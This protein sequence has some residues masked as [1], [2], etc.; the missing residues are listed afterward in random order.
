MKGVRKSAFKMPSFLT[1]LII[2]LVVC[3]LIYLAFCNVKN[4]DGF[5]YGG[6]NANKYTASSKQVDVNFNTNS[7]GDVMYINANYK[8][9]DGVGAVHIHTNDNGN[10]GPI[11]AWLGT[12]KQWQ[13]GVKQNTP[14]TNAP[15]C[16]PNNPMCTLAAPR[17]TPYLKD[18]ANTQRSFIVKKSDCGGN[19]C[20]WLKNG[21]MLVVHGT[22][23]QQVVNGA[24]TSGQPGIDVLSATPFASAS[25]SKK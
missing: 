25:A 3:F 21:V 20:P 15:C 23:F 7:S 9:L 6:N 14:G 18:L 8:N 2:L 1:L 10:P 11:L 12:S 17:E 5:S 13:A 4:T 24:L 22:N 16:S 19:S